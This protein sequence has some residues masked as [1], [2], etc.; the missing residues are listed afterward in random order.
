MIQKTCSAEAP[1]RQ[2]VCAF[3]SDILAG[4]SQPQKAIPCRYFYDE[5]GSALFEQI[6]VLPE[7][8]PT[9]TEI[10]IL[11]SCASQI[12]AHTP[13]GTALIE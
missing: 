1:L 9:R 11:Q 12:A 8:Y 13:E 5:A 6:T 4:L 7:Y 3:G 10:G 2:Q